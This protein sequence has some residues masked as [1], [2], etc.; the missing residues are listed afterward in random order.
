MTITDLTRGRWPDLLQQFGGLTPDQ[1]TDK[2]QPCPC[3][4]GSDRYRFDDKDGTGSWYCN[5]CGGRDGAGG[6]GSGIDLL[7]RRTGWSYAEAC[8]RIEAHLSVTPEPPTAGAEY[9]WRYSST[10]YVCRFPGKAIRPLWWDGD[11]W[12]WKAPPAPRPLYWA[13]Q[14]P[15]APVLVVEGEKAADAAARLFPT[16]AVCT[17]PSGCK[18]ISKAD[19]S[20]VAGRA[21]TL[22]PDADSVGRQAMAKLAP[23][24]LQAGARQVRIVRPP[25]GV[26]EGWDLADAD[27]TPAEAAAYVVAHR[28][29]PLLPAPPVEEPIEEPAEECDP[30]PIPAVSDH[31]ACLGFDQDAYYY[32]PAATG[33]VMRLGRG[34][35]TSTNLCA[36]APLA[37]WESCYPGGRGGPNWTAAA[38][39]LFEQCAAIGVYSPERIRGRGAWWD[40]GRSV[41]HLGDRLIVDGAEQSVRHPLQGSA[42]IYQ[43]LASLEAAHGA[44]PLDDQAGNRLLDIADRFRWEVPASGLL[45]A[46]WVA[47]APICGALRWRPHLWL[48]AGAGSGKSA[49]LDRFVAPLLGEIGLSVAGNTT[50]PGIRQALR[51]DARPVVFDEA[52]SNERQDQQRMQA[53]LGLA[54]VASSESRA[55]TLKGSPDG[56]TQRYTIRSM[57]LLSSIATGLKQGADKSRFA[58]LTLRSPSEMPREQR[59]QHWQS[60]D[61]DLD[62]YVSDAIGRR[63]QARTVS[64]IPTIRENIKTFVQVAAERFDSQRLG[65]QYGTLLAGAWSLQS[66]ALVTPDDALGLINANNWEPYSQATEVPDEQRCFQRIMQHHVRVEADRVVTRAIGELVSI[67]LNHD[68]DQ[69]VTPS[70]AHAVLGRHGI[71]LRDGRVLISNTAE[72][73]AAIL[74]DT[75]WAS[76]WPTV[77]ARLPGAQRA[78]VIRFRGA[79]AVSRAVSVT[80]E[81]LR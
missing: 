17:W 73:I 13:R 38:S 51:A 66:T 75:A 69:D 64:L 76:C 29:E 62:R 80:V 21:I 15:G 36:L 2:H 42:Y 48:T 4:G 22:W 34:S 63:L 45:L 12:R 40:R 60:L 41:L 53:V 9:V 35:H 46:G 30:P 6:G 8:R 1:L 65:D 10:F 33:Q 72:A 70:T 37:Y 32:Q 58:Q 14:L 47:L 11:A 81:S 67:G 28:T 16:V 26:P 43:R 24:L 52:E 78:G 59:I 27:W 61:H 19:W 5:Q 54:R 39:S 79:G 44:E 68:T 3:C 31:Y 18:A 77:L 49:I 23:L 25:D 7:M 74:R 57:F 55:S 56:D 71:A 20:P 50:E